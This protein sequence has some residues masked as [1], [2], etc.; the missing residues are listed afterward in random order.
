MESL[1]HLILWACTKHQSNRKIVL[2]LDALDESDPNGSGRIQLFNFLQSLSDQNATPEGSRVKILIGTRPI[3]QIPSASQ[4][5]S[6][7]LQD[8][9]RK[10]IEI[11]V[12]GLL[13]EPVFDKHQNVKQAI[14]DFILRHCDGVFLWVRLV[15]E[16]LQTCASKAYSDADM[17]RELKALPTDL[18]DF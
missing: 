9:N 3:K 7:V 8:R 14:K 10:D 4:C 5:H 12:D 2:V 13:G 17:L 16:E 18:E 11:Y 15:L 1:R 6:I